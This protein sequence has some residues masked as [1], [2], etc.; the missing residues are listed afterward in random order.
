MFSVSNHR[1]LSNFP[2]TT[3]PKK[4][5]LA[6][7]K[8]KKKKMVALSLIHQVT[9]RFNKVRVLVCTVE[10]GIVYGRCG[11][12]DFSGDR[13]QAAVGFLPVCPDSDFS[14]C[15]IT[16]AGLCYFRN[17]RLNIFKNSIQVNLEDLMAEENRLKSLDMQ[18]R[19]CNWCKSDTP[20]QLS[21]CLHCH[22][23]WHTYWLAWASVLPL[24]GIPFALARA[25]LVGSRAYYDKR[26]RAL[27]GVEIFFVLVDIA[28]APFIVASIVNIAPRLAAYA[29][30]AAAAGAAAAAASGLV[31]DA[32][33][34]AIKAVIFAGSMAGRAVIAGGA[35]VVDRKA[36][37]NHNSCTSHLRQY[38][39][40]GEAFLRNFPCRCHD[41][42]QVKK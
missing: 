27:A 23:N 22:G 18:V 24:I 26:N 1:R 10:A 38:G 12:I 2:S 28:T 11:V 6:P 9:N 39:T 21:I 3:A 5:E 13:P 20:K 7:L 19:I 16:D 32:V 14:L 42:R 34:L 36:A 29:T 8:T 4:L 15:A 30:R 33:A 40:E 35:Q 31:D 17:Y 37:V 25:T 41:C